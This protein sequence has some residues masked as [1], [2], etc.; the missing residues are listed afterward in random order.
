MSE[1]MRQKK[2]GEDKNKNNQR[3]KQVERNADKKNAATS[4]EEKAGRGQGKQ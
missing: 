4:R 3:M 2:D 1:K